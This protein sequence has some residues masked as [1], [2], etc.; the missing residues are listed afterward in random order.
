[1][2]STFTPPSISRRTGAPGRVDPLAHFGELP[3]A[4]LGMNFCPPNPGFT[5]MISTM[6]I[7]SSV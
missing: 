6:S 1:M 4:P 3:Q 2:L 5:D 7:F